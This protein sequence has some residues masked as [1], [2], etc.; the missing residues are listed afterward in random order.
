MLLFLRYEIFL[1]FLIILTLLFQFSQ[2]KAGVFNQLI[3]PYFRTI[4]Q[5]NVQAATVEKENDIP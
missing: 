5:V 1:I 4:G 3:N 2:L